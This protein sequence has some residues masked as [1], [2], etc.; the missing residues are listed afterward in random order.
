MPWVTLCETLG[1]ATPPGTTVVNR[2]CVQVE[3]EGDDINDLRLALN[4]GAGAEGLRLGSLG[5]VAV[6]VLTSAEWDQTDDPSEVQK[7][8]EAALSTCFGCLNLLNVCGAMTLGTVY[9]LKAAQQCVMTRFSHVKISEKQPADKRA[10]PELFQKV[11]A[12]ARKHEWFADCLGVYVEEPTFY[13]VYKA[14]EAIRRHSGGEAAMKARNDLNGSRLAK[15][16]TVAD[17]HRHIQSSNRAKP[18]PFYS[19]DDCVK[20]VTQAIGVLLKTELG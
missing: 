17:Y 10:S 3:G 18:N 16:K 12:V 5:P 8:A 20:E 14:V 11:L 13:S 2:W 9:E 15:V 19:L 7:L 4:G 1:I 6:P